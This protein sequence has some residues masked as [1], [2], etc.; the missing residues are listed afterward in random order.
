MNSKKDELPSAESSKNLKMSF[1][2]TF[3]STR[4]PEIATQKLA[5]NPTPTF[6]KMV[7]S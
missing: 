6:Y 3:C 2:G 4:E 7:L 5:E 1:A